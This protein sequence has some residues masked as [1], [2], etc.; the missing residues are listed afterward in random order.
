[1]ETLTAIS[2][3]PD[4]NCTIFR[5]MLLLSGGWKGFSAGGT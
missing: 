2:S 1:M 5:G 4:E 3:S